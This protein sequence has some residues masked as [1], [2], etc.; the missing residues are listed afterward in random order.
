MHK[1]KIFKKI[2]CFFWRV[3]KASKTLTGVYNEARASVHMSFEA[4]TLVLLKLLCEPN[5][6]M[7]HCHAYAHG[8]TH[9]LVFAHSFIAKLFLKQFCVA[10]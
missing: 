9:V 6:I 8:D 5:S 7:A 1:H 3:S 10:I 2:I 4:Q